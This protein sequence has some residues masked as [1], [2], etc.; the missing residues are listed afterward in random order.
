VIGE[1]ERCVGVDNVGL[2]IIAEVVYSDFI[3]VVDVLKGF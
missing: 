2:I 3:I 1:V